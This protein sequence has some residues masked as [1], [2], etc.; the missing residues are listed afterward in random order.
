VTPSRS[1][2]DQPHCR[3]EPEVALRPAPGRLLVQ[4]TTH[5]D[6]EV[7]RRNSGASLPLILLQGLSWL[8]V[9][10]TSLARL[11]RRPWN[12]GKILAA[13]TRRSS[14]RATRGHTPT[15][16]SQPAQVSCR[17][18][19][20]RLVIEDSI[21]WRDQL[22][23]VA[24]GLEKR[25]TQRRWT[26]RTNFLIE[27]DIM[28]SAY[29]IRKLHEARKISDQLARRKLNVKRFK[30]VGKVLDH[31]SRE[32]WESFDLESPTETQVSLTF[33]CNQI[34][35]SFAWIISATEEGE[36]FDGVFVSSD[37]ERRRFLYFIHVDLLIGLFREVGEE[38]IVEMSMSADENGERYI[39]Q[40]ISA[41]DRANGIQIVRPDR[42]TVRPSSSPAAS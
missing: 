18:R 21:P 17:P 38:D 41:T 30:L 3:R 35:H 22:I 34:I 13:I 29:A 4:T 31:W 27:R 1:S 33:L 28:T 32:F 12:C 25:K 16:D 20:G 15:T 14:F 5:I 40:V 24:D 9:M 11:P 37:R 7:H 36:L 8:S 2:T 19:Y 42:P 39:A 23:R 6:A 10:I 26:D